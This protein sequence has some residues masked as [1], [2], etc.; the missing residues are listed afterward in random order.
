MKAKIWNDSKWISETEPSKLKSYFDRAIRE[1]GFQV[2]DQLEH[3]FE[4]YGYTGLWL[5]GE[6]HFA[7]HTFP[8][9]GK[10]YIELS[11]CNVDYYFKYLQ[12]TKDLE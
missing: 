7:V 5:L 6:S 2:L 9:V 8:E 11:S 12:L 3:Y 1:C 10:T 4:P